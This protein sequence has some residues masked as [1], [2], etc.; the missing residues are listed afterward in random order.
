MFTSNYFICFT[1]E[2]VFPAHSDPYGTKIEIAVVIDKYSL[3]RGYTH[4]WSIDFSKI[5]GAN[6]TVSTRPWAEETLNLKT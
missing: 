4:N 5:H 2:P 6:A 1:Y 3:G